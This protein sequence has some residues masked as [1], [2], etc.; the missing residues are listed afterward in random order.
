MKLILMLLLFFT[1]GCSD[2]KYA[3]DSEKKIKEGE[4]FYYID[5]MKSKLRIPNRFIL[6]YI[7][8]NEILKF[9]SGSSLYTDFS[10]NSTPIGSISIGNVSQCDVCKSIL[11]ANTN[12][13]ID[14]FSTET[15]GEYNINRVR[16]KNYPSY[17]SI[18]IY[19]ETSYI[20]IIDKQAE[21]ILGEFNFKVQHVIK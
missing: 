18:I 7:P 4:G 5:I 8:D 6:F 10:D 16:F 17:L 1:I 12:D 15:R 21:D 3:K 11:D 20:Q 9:V 13:K 19:N 14:F 2:L